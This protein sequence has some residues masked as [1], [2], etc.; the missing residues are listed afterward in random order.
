MHFAE[1]AAFCKF[2]GCF[3]ISFRFAG[4]TYNNIRSY[5]NIRHL[6]F[7]IRQKCFKFS[8]CVRPVHGLQGFIAARLQR[9]VQMP[10]KTCVFL[11]QR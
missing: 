1:A 5:G 9:Q 6:R 2:A 11:H 10:A 4:K 7:N 8:R 3:K